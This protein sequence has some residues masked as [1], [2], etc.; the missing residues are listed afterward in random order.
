MN[1]VPPTD[2]DSVPLSVEL[3][4]DRV[5]VRFEAAWKAGQR[6][7]IE[8]YLAGVEASERPVFLRELLLLDLDYRTKSDEQPPASEYHARFPEDAAVIDA[9]FRRM[10]GSRLPP[11]PAS[12]ASSASGQQQG[13]SPA[14]WPCI[15]GYELRR[16]L[17]HGGM[18]VVYEARQVALDRLVAVKLFRADLHAGEDE[19]ARFRGDAEVVARLAHPHIVAIYDIGEAGGRPFFALELVEGGSLADTIEGTPQPA[20][21]AAKLVAVLARAMH[22]VHQRGIVHRDLKP[23]NMLL[24]SSDR[25]EA[26]QLGS[27]PEDVAGYEPKI[28]DFGLAKRL[29]L[30]VGR[31][32]P[33]A[34]LGTPSYMAPEQAGGRNK[35]IG[36][37]TDVY[38]LGATLYELLTGRPPFRAGTPLDTMLQ[39]ISDE[40][41]PPARLNPMVPRDLETVCLKCLEKEPARRYATAEELAADLGRFLDGEPV[42]ARPVSGVERG[43]RW[44]R[45]HPAAT[46]LIAASGVA[47]LALV[48]LAVAGY[49]TMWLNDAREGEKAQRERA[50]GLL[51]FMS[52]ERA[53]SAWRENDVKRADEILA[54]CDPA[55]RNWEWG[56]L[57][58]LCH[59]DL[60][61]FRGHTDAVVAVAWSSDGS[62]L[63]SASVDKTVKIWDVQ[64][65]EEVLSLQGYTGA[66]GGMAFSPDGTRLASASYDRGATNKPGEVKLWDARTG[67]ELRT[68]L[69]H[70]GGVRGVAWSPDGTRL[71]SA[72][73]D[74]TVKVWDTKTGQEVLSLQGHTE[75]VMGVAWS[76]DG[77]RL[78]SASDGYLGLRE[79]VFAEVKVWDAKNGQ[80]VLTPEGHM[81]PVCGVV[82]SP[83][84]ARLASAWPGQRRSDFPSPVEGGVTIWDA[85]TGR[86]MLTLKEHPGAV[87][88]IA[89][90]P[91]GTHLASAGGWENPIVMVR[92]SHTGQEVLTLKGHTGAVN[93]VA[94]SPDGK[95]LA[96]ASVDRTVKVWEV[97]WGQEALVLKGHTDEV[98]GVAWSP[99][100]R[101]LASASWDKTVKVWDAQTG[102]EALT[103]KGHGYE[104]HGD[105]VWVVAWSPDGQRLAS[106]GVHWWVNVWDARTGK[107]ALTLMGHTDSVFGVCF[108]PDGKRLASASKDKTVKVWDAQTGQEILTIKGHTDE[109]LGVAWSPDGTRLASASN[110]QTVKVWDAQ[111]GQEALSLQGHTY[112]AWSPD[113]KRLASAGVDG[114]VKVWD[115][116][117]GRET[118]SLQGKNGR[119][120]W[121]P[122]GT[123][124]A[125]ASLGN[126]VKVWDAKTGQEA[127][128]LRGHAGGVWSVAW[129][130]D[131]SR[132]ASAGGRGDLTVRVWPGRPLVPPHSEP[133]VPREAPQP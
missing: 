3:R 16:E 76:P 14:D 20:R 82:W 120:A 31:T 69:G 70:T 41:V 125:S 56:Y 131:G 60:R 10:C 17:G 18:G 132:L 59:S 1:E 38:A 66:V 103:L 34:I 104:G 13:G 83:D 115:A 117:T 91:D 51:Y 6:P 23:A 121:S 97:E 47:L 93:S 85:K 123:R 67:Q 98:Q 79:G 7:R 5:C 90:S 25:P 9:V 84:G 27:T 87:N 71:A 26:V 108:S 39:V 58:R 73:Y 19:L 92:D 8:E 106:A 12:G 72:S 15:P 44:A 110:D 55:L 32:Q 62:R 43:L 111:T 42:V 4:V 95:R 75:A 100:G 112:V 57:Y 127:L 118:L 30:G 35:E 53:H 107:E 128:T 94:F 102:Q 129:S 65:G 40:P 52:I 105:E 36:P 133:E 96:S 64:T 89:L 126:T 80:E 24:V 78:A 22:F 54:G 68:L 50:D 124:L 122:D 114:T 116:S 81:A 2:N 45:R 119:V 29:D 113:G 74:K 130:P 48:G 86:E 28:T 49:Y 99:D 109:V 11:P 46:G 61:T 63:A 77:K 21:Q 101:R 88:G 37:A 33:G